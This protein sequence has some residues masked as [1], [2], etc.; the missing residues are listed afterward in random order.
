MAFQDGHA[1]S[2]AAV[3]SQRIPTAAQHVKS[4]GAFPAPLGTACLPGEASVS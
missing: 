2:S 4:L 3:V 1:S